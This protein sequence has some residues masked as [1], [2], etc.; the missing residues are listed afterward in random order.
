M[1]DGL[2]LTFTQPL[3]LLG[4]LGLPLLWLLLRITPPQARE[5][6]FPPLSLILDLLPAQK[7]A[8]RTPWWLTA[9][10]LAMAALVIIALAGPLWRPPQQG[11]LAPNHPVLILMDDGW[12]SATDWTKRQA[13]AE[14]L[15]ASAAEHQQAVALLGFSQ[16]PHALHLGP[17][18][19][20]LSVLQSLRPSA[21]TPD[22][23]S[24]LAAITELAQTITDLDIVIISDGLTMRTH[25]ETHPDFM[26]ALQSRLGLRPITIV[27]PLDSLWSLT[28]RHDTDTGLVVHMVRPSAG[29]AEAVELVLRDSQDRVLGRHSVRLDA[30]ETTRQIEMGLPLEL[31]LELARIDIDQHSHAGAVWLSDQGQNRKRVAL[32]SD[33]Q[34]DANRALLSPLTY[35]TR[36]LSPYAEIR[37]SRLGSVEAIATLLDE[38][39]AML[40][41]AETGQLP[42]TSQ[43]KLK[44]YMQQG[45]IVL[46]F[47]SPAWTLAQDAL[48]PVPLRRGGRLLGGALSWETPRSLAPFD[49][50]SPFAELTI[51]ADISI[52]RQILAEPTPDLAKKTWASLQDGTPL[53]TADRHGKGLLVLFHVSAEASWSNLPLSGLFVSMLQKIMALSHQ[54]PSDATSLAT[55]SDALLPPLRLLDGYG[56]WQTKPAPALPLD[57]KHTKTA[58]RDYPAGLYG[59]DDSPSA[60]NI[61]SPDMTL[62]PLD[63][64]GAHV[65]KI[66]LDTEQATDLRPW[67]LSLTALL[68]LLDG[69]ATLFL[70]GALSFKARPL[71][72][73]FT[74]I[75][76][77]F[78]HPLAAAEFSPKDRDSALATRLAYILT[79]DQ[80]IDDFSRLGLTELSAFLSA[81]TA[82]EPAAPVGVNPSR[83]ELGVYPLLYWPMLANQRTPDAQTIARIEAYMK[84]GGTILFDTRDASLQSHTGS[85]TAETKALQAILS[86]MTIPPLDV[87][88]PS[89]VILKTFFLIDQFPGR[90]T[91]GKTY[92]EATHNF[93]AQTPSPSL[94]GSDGVSS[95][96]ITSN[97]LAAAWASPQ[98]GSLN[99]LNQT[100]PRQREM[101]LRGGANIV[102]YVLTGNYKSDQ[103]HVPALLERL[104]P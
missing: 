62:H 76:L 52:S 23:H 50:Q 94:R 81:R 24:H 58:T 1:A 93:D 45:G 68:F 87:V 57:I 10:R 91:N 55:S 25:E 89:H 54:L 103:V 29:P 40:I 83:D 59:A 43:A 86:Q 96:I 22:R 92:I 74:L 79:G 14:G 72:L 30:H 98:S 34:A 36:A 95:L 9:L 19:S 78:S 46:R 47:A 31:R 51:P 5:I 66:P 35:L 63:M 3:L 102:M 12:A 8:A 21:F 53:V 82:L 69:L 67:L 85:V 99:L 56:R 2:A 48:V 26:Q 27:T 42:E 101:A 84:N 37:Q 18:H 4:L 28:G 88:P 7:T 65:R 104:G 80:T 44:A 17:A 49:S 70:G 97:D 13:F 73:L 38:N 33:G 61:L 20:A 32:I 90:T 15:I 64:S 75:T 77:G 6:R 16:A 41:L 60:L 39:P 71:I 100:I 11:V